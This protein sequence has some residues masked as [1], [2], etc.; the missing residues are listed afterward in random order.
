MIK[1][2]INYKRLKM[3]NAGRLPG[4]G[5]LPLAPLLLAQ[6]QPRHRPAPAQPRAARRGAGC[7]AAMR[8]P[9]AGVC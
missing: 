4:G 5:L 2:K 7:G 3:F 8:P 9:A 1:N 6:E